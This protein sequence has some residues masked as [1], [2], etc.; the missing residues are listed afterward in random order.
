LPLVIAQDDAVVANNVALTDAPAVRITGA[1][2]RFSNSGTLLSSSDSSAA[3]IL[4]GA[5]THLFNDAAGI[6]RSQRYPYSFG[7]AIIGSDGTD[8]IVNEGRI[9]GDVDLG[10]GDDSFTQRSASQLNELLMGEGDDVFRI[11]TQSNL[12]MFASGG[13]GWDRLVIGAD[14][15]NIYEAVAEFEALDLL[16]SFANLS[17]FGGYHEMTF[18]PGGSFNFLQSRNPLLDV[19]IDGVELSI[20]SGSQFRD[21]TGG[22]GDDRVG[23]SDPQIGTGGGQIL[24]NV[25]LGGGDDMFGFQWAYGGA[26]ATVAGT[27]EGGAG[28]DRLFL[29]A[30]GGRTIDLSGFSGFE[31][32]N[33]GYGTSIAIDMRIVGANGFGSINLQSGG[34]LT[35]AGSSAP[36][37]SLFLGAQSIAAIE[38]TTTLALISAANGSTAPGGYPAIQAADETK[39]VS[40]TNSG[41]VLGDVILCIGSDDYDGRG[42]SVGG[43]VY[44]LAGDDSILM[45]AGA[46]R[47]DGGHGADHVEGGAGG[48]ELTGG[49]GDDWLVG[50]SGEDVLFG[51]GGDDRL[52]GGDDFDQLDGG[53]GSDILYGDAGDDVF[54]DDDPDGGGG[55]DQMFGGEGWDS[56]HI[57]RRGLSSPNQ[58]V[59][60]GG[61]GPDVITFSPHDW[62]DDATLIGGDGDDQISAFWGRSLTIDA[63]AGNDR[64]SLNFLG[65]T[66]SVT[67]GSGRD[68]LALAAYDGA[69]PA[70]GSITVTDFETGDLGDRLELLTYLVQRLDGWD[71]ETNPF[72]TQHL[73]LVQDGADTLLELD[74]DG[75]GASD[76]FAAL[77]RLQ[78]VAA[79]GLNV[80]NLGGYAGDGTTPDLTRITGTPGLDQLWG[81]GGMDIIQGL[82]SQDEIFGGAGDD[83]I[84]GGG[85]DDLLY[86]QYGDDRLFGEAG[87]DNLVDQ[88]GGDDQFFGGGERDYL[89][90]LRKDSMPLSNVLLDGGEGDDHLDFN[91]LHRT[92]GATIL[93]GNGNDEIRIVGEGEVVA[94]AGAGADHVLINYSNGLFDLTLGDGADL[95]EIKADFGF[96]NGLVVVVGDFSP[97]SDRIDLSNYLAQRLWGWD[98][99]VNPFAAGYLR[100]GQRGS[101]VLLTIDRDGASGAESFSTLIV[102]E[103]LDARALTAADLGHAPG[104]IALL[105]TGGA[106]VIEGRPGNDRME[107]GAGDDV[108][109]VQDS[110]DMVVEAA[111][112]GNDRIAAA[113]GYALA[114]GSEVETI[115]TLTQSETIALNLTGNEFAQLIVGNNGANLLDGGGGDDVLVGLG[116]NDAL[117]GGG[118]SDIMHGGLGD[119]TYYVQDSGD[120]VFENGGEGSDRIA[121]SISFA[122]ASGSEVETI[123][124]ITQSATDALNLYGSEYAQLVIGNEGVNL[125]DGGGGGDVL[126]GLG[127]NDALLGGSG[128]D[129]M[130]GGTGNDTYYVQDSGD[131]VFENAGEGVDR[132]ASSIS[133][134]LASGS[135]VETIE[136]ITQSDTTALNL[137]GSEYAQI[138][139]GNNGANLLD[140][141][142]GDDVLLGLGGNDAL[143][144]G[145]GNDA[146][147]G[148]LGNDT[149]YVQDAGDQAFENGGEGVDRI[150][151]SVSFALAAGSEVETLETI[152]QSDTAAL[153]LTGNA[154][155]QLLIGNAGANVLN[156]GG[157]ADVLIGLGGADSFAFTAALGGSNVDVIAGFVSGSDR[158]LLDDAAFAGLGL[159]A[160]GANAFV[161]GGAAQDADDRILYD[162]ATGALYFDADGSG[163]GAA[164][165]FATLDGLPPIAASDFTVI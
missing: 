103:N 108:Y 150:A 9:D 24:G 22:D 153:D 32:I 62:R 20:T 128:S 48:D 112:Q 46:D 40:L 145:S 6:I 78:N 115:E 21:I 132:I 154:F 156:G 159:G 29:V 60:D 26:A 158:I 117:L 17:G 130:Y 44:G 80:Y 105:G 75:A 88:E 23:L 151:T 131:Q 69:A 84:E 146:M 16:G 162:A 33:E 61:G 125:L 14:V 127:G 74:S 137:Y 91:A 140:G 161:A 12:Q 45:G 93:G 89:V 97:G 109:Y 165:R 139:I 42:G 28:H 87:T 163:S 164:V 70:A 101:D 63:G 64:V 148:G 157:G 66:T 72:A 111:G 82:G 43:T 57:N 50:G 149:Y 71:P 100:L 34:K 7:D 120:Q 79:S 41:T 134:A 113:V 133:F 2:V 143:L 92:D 85:G 81:T 104:A 49:D 1:R 68:F 37:G 4:D 15:T 65:A 55:N 122:L 95:V 94:D 110:G 90:I 58:V 126:A 8:T 119:D 19:A 36:D 141:G 10:G 13:A 11:E 53:T 47:A 129:I 77:L 99:A 102:F 54:F 83:W 144:G 107:G 25:D 147:H 56:M 86:G 160:L 114:A 124:T 30:T 152:T 118:G 27:V 116:G 3:I 142:G 123:E 31:S 96:G 38:A 136:T 52:E 39:A 51:G 35:L 121:T 59:M 138:V 155:A 98:G 18:A 76:T 135:E 73:R 67:L 5:G 106:D